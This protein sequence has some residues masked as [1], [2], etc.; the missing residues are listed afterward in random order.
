MI[1]IFF[2]SFIRTS[3]GKSS[4]VNAMLQ[5][6][7]LPSGLG[8]T[9]NCFLQVEGSES[10]EAYVMTEDSA[11]PQSVQVFI[12][13]LFLLKHIFFINR[14]LARNFMQKLLHVTNGYFTIDSWSATVRPAK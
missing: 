6:K 2:F 12:L 13:S 7:I 3:N 14:L 10:S 9:T 8:H 4:V 1:I 5:D 11:E